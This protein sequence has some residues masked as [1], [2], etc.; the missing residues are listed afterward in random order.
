MN[1]LHERFTKLHQSGLLIL[2]NAWDAGST[3]LLASLGYAAI[4]TTSAG[5]A[6][7][8]PTIDSPDDVTTCAPAN[9]RPSS[10][11]VR[12]APVTTARTSAEPQRAHRRAGSARPHH[13][14]CAELPA[15]LSASGPVQCRQRAMFRHRLQAS[16]GT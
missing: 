8:S 12:R 5:P 14:H 7:I 1:P 6:P 10:S 11:A 16:D 4:A 2:P 13:R 3:R 9:A 15:A